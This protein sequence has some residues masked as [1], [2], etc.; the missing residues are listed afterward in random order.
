MKQ[1]ITVL[2]VFLAVT[3]GMHARYNDINYNLN[4]SGGAYISVPY[5]SSLDSDLTI[6]GRFTIDAWIKPAAIG[7]DMA[8]VGNNYAY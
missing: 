4:V 3:G 2:L 5:H 7:S 8:I 6:A 1:A